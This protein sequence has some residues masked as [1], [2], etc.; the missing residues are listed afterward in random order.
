MIRVLVGNEEHQVSY[1][2]VITVASNLLSQVRCAMPTLAKLTIKLVITQHF[3]FIV[4]HSPSP[5]LE[6]EVIA[7]V[8]GMKSENVCQSTLF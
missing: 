1:R 2:E 3:Y 4:L 7:R 8:E 5:T 6:V